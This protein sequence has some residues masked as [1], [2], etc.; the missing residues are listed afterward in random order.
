[1]KTEQ[2]DKDEKRRISL[3]FVNGVKS[4]QSMTTSESSSSPSNKRPAISNKI[5]LDK[6]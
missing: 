3:Q 6:A 5:N 1:M 2:P 4:L